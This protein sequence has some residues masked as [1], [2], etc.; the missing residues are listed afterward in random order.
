MVVHRFLSTALG[1]ICGSKQLYNKI[2]SS[3]LDE[4]LKRY[5]KAMSQ[6][7]FLLSVERNR[8]PYTL[9]NYFNQTLQQLRSARVA[10][11]LEDNARVDRDAWTTGS[12]KIVD[13]DAVKKTASDQGNVEHITG[14][15]HDILWSYYQVARER[16][17][18]NVHMQAIEHCLLTGPESPL[19]VFSQEWVINLEP[20]EL[21]AIA[22]ESQAT[23]ARRTGL[24]QKMED[25]KSALQTLKF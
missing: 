17:V 6:A 7:L 20:E 23:K 25:L 22:G 18:D 3:I 5:E 24:K 2:W 13:L 1:K 11:A 9:N 19:E 10:Q 15:I 14:E 8:R 16:F 12:A 4:L 21:A